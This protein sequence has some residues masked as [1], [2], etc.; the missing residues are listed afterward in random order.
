M[1]GVSRLKTMLVQPIDMNL[2][3]IFLYLKKRE[4]LYV[5]FLNPEKSLEQMMEYIKSEARKK[6]VNGC[7]MLEDAVVY[8]LA[9]HYFDETNEALG[10]I[11]KEKKVSNTKKENVNNSNDENEKVNI[12]NNKNEDINNSIEIPSDMEQACL[13]GGD[14]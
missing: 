13:F 8:G 6:A 7:A 9:V 5:K 3:K 11:K 10:L 12:V 4:D 14:M 1:D 2:F